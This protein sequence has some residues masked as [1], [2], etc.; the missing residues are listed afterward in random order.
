MGMVGPLLG[1]YLAG[2]H[3]D[4]ATIGVIVSSGLGGAT[5]ATLWV[6]LFVKGSSRRGVLLAVAVLSLV[7]G[8]VALLASGPWIVGAAAFVGMLNGMGR[9]R[10][11]CLVVEQSMLPE[12]ARHVDRTKAFAWYGAIQDAG[13]AIGGLCSGL[14][15]LLRRAGGLGDLPSLRVSMGA[16][17]VVLASS[18]VPY[19]LLSRGIAEQ[20]V[21]SGRG[22]S[23]GSRTILTRISALFAIDSIAG[24]FLSS[25]FLALFFRRR[26]D[27]D[28]ATIGALFA[29]R[30]VLNAASHFGAAW[31]AKRIGLVNTM[32]FTHI[33]SSILLVTVPMAPTFGVA[34]IIFL[35][36]E[37]LVEM[38][39]PTR[40]SYLMAV[41]QAQERAFASGVTHLVRMGGWAVAP[42]IAGYVAN[43]TNSL[44]PLLWMGAGIKIT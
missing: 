12:T 30:S 41:V 21:R 38:D 8:G 31:L 44:A 3:F 1:F 2:L 37:G 19:F 4:D 18:A 23:T 20:P 32:V 5:L 9:D 40:T 27:A 11:A 42:L 34:A 33:P 39:V 13:A 43:A 35:V 17:L 24:G 28:E 10:G 15:A 29:A 25:S 16:Y 22:V 14:P 26:F 6:T 7:G 36:R